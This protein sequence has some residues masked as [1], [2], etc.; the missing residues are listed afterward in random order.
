VFG[1]LV[2][3]EGEAEDAGVGGDDGF[4]VGRGLG[5]EGEGG[6][7]EGEGAHVSGRRGGW[8]SAIGCR[9][10]SRGR[11]RRRGGR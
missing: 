5:L 1:G 2:G 7:E 10:R 3:G 9:G 6:E 11:G 8:R 4:E